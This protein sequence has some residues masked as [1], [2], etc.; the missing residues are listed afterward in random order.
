MNDNIHRIPFNSYQNIQ[1]F[2]LTFLFNYNFQLFDESCEHFHI[3]SFIF[4]LKKSLH[5]YI[6]IQR[7]NQA[8]DNIPFPSIYIFGLH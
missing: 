7:Y 3:T 6:Y 2:H 4:F 5:L 1:T 8:S